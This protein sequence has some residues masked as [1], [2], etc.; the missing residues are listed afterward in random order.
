[1]R[2]LVPAQEVQRQRAGFLSVRDVLSL[3]QLDGFQRSGTSQR[4][5]PESIAMNR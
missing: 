2:L 3:E 1:M 4:V 5:S